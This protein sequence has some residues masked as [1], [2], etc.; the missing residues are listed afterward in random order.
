MNLLKVAKKK[1]GQLQWRFYGVLVLT[2]ECISHSRVY[3][4]LGMCICLQRSHHKRR[5]KSKVKIFPCF[6]HFRNHWNCESR[7]FLGIPLSAGDLGAA[8]Q[9]NIIVNFEELF[10]GWVGI[11]YYGKRNYYVL[12]NVLDITSGEGSFKRFLLYVFIMSRTRFRVN[13][14]SYFVYELSVCGFESS[15]SH[16]GFLVFYWFGIGIWDPIPAKPLRTRPCTVFG[17]FPLEFTCA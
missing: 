4:F 5:F 13:P 6:S 17:T 2:F 8:A 14:H 7:D 11:I 10:M 1:P 16:L 15:C 9:K 3:H 12:I